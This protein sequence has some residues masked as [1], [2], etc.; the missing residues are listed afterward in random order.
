MVLSI[1]TPYLGNT[2]WGRL[3]VLHTSPRCYFQPPL[4]TMPP[5]SLPTTLGNVLTPSPLAS[6]K[7]L[8]FFMARA[9]RSVSKLADP[10]KGRPAVAVRVL[11][12]SRSYTDCAHRD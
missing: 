4:G 12:R 5:E 6:T 11:W 3:P 10:E 8:P 7:S 2:A 1:G 9:L